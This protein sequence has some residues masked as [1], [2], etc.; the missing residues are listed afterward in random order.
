MHNPMGPLVAALVVMLWS[1]TA[2][3]V[4]IYSVFESS[5]STGFTEYNPVSIQEL[6]QD[7][8]DSTTSAAE[9]ETPVPDGTFSQLAC[10]VEDAPG[11]GKSWTFTLMKN[12]AV[13]SLSCVVSDTSRRCSDTSNTVAVD[14]GDRVTLLSTPLSTPASTAGRCTLRFE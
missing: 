4:Q 6:V 10:V 1:S 14:T 8:P 11:G 13:S 2:G 9:A 12:G 3:A 5:L 7:S